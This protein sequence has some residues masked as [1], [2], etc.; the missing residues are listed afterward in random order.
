[1]FSV[2]NFV[3]L[4]L[5]ISG[6]ILKLFAVVNSLFLDLNFQILHEINHSYQN[7]IVTGQFR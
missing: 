2:E 5:F 4:M 3:F 6:L 1:M 7:R